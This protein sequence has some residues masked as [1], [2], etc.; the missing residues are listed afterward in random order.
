MGTMQN[1]YLV[2]DIYKTFIKS[3]T[4]NILNTI[5]VVFM[6]IFVPVRTLAKLAGQL[7]STNYLIG[8]VCFAAFWVKFLGFKEKNSPIAMYTLFDNF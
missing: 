6:K 4:D 7:I 8:V 5:S 2:M 3:R 1:S